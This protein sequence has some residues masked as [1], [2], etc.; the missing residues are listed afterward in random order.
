[1][2]GTLHLLVV[3]SLML[4]LAYLALLAAV[5]VAAALRSGGRREESADD[6]GVFAG[7]RFTM[8][9]SVIIP[10]IGD[11]P[12]A[13]RA[14]ASALALD[15]PEFEVIVVAD[16]LVDEEAARLRD[17][18]SLSPRE[19]FYRQVLTAG[20]VRQIF[21]S[22]ADPRL[23]LVHKAPGPVADAMNCG[24]NLAQYRYV[25]GIDSAL[26]FDHDA[27]LRAMTPALREPA[28][29][30]AVSTHVERVDPQRPAGTLLHRFQ[31]LASLR[32]L[33]ETKIGWQT[34]SAGIGP[35]DAVVVW[36]RDAIV[37]ARGFSTRAADPSLDL[38]RGLQADSGP[39]AGRVA[40]QWDVFGSLAPVG[41]G[42]SVRLASRRQRAVL[43]TVWAWNHR[44]PR[45]GSERAN[46][47]RRS[48]RWFVVCE[49]LS[50]VVAAWAVVS[51]LVAGAA[52][53]L[54]WIDVAAVALLLSFGRALVSSA[55]LLVRGA[56]PG[57]PDERD[58]RRLL[59][60]AP[61]ELV[62]TGVPLAIA[63]LSGAMR[64]RV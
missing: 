19:Y 42:A 13:D 47:M 64:L 39:D 7:S 24:V 41:L 57:S 44:L 31:H 34:L 15:Y 21:R 4:A 46:N 25:V 35:H 49:M 54:P 9:I 32:S 22:T 52:G 62:V 2:T 48:L 18:W 55:A 26:T 63:R 59:A 28:H 36:R 43:Q 16:G 61:F 3:S 20:E 29:V 40:R 51:A 50:P 14:I 17:K 38:M 10:L 8:P 5:T 56:L 27:L 30:V 58:L 33:M 23:L 1:M 60:A 6:D 37:A 53:W 45:D 11:D 12:G